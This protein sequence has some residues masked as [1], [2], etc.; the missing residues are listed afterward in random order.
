MKYT[1]RMADEML[2]T[3]DLDAY[4]FHGVVAPLERGRL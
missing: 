3:T 4:C 1:P 2:R